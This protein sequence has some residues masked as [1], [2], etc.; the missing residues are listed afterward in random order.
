MDLTNFENWLKMNK[1]SKRT[2]SNYLQQV[3]HFF[4]EYSEFNQENIDNYFLKVK[5]EKSRNTFNAI[6][7]ALRS[8]C[9]FSRQEINFPKM[10]KQKKT[11]I[12]YYIREEELN[13]FLRSIYEEDD[14]LIRFMFYTGARSQDVINV[15]KSDIDFKNK[16]VTFYNGKGDKDR[17]VPFTSKEYF[18]RLK[19]YCDVLEREK[20]F[21]I[22][23]QR[24]QRLFKKIQKEH[25]LKD[26]VVE[27][28]TMRKSFAKHCLIG[29]L[30]ISHIQKAL[31]HNDIKTTEIYAEPDQKMVEEAFKKMREELI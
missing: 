27:P 28:R 20:V 10:R 24:L 16:R 3:S 8:Y 18:K 14:L 2:V 12:K 25:D 29:G 30:D 5:E 31:G 9:E 22:N 21:N 15:K 17:V 6:L 23:Q 13:D 1:D 7:T 4:K 26:Q 19:S 11:T